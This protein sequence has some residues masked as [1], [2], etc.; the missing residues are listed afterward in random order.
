MNSTDK[1]TTNKNTTDV[2]LKSLTR[3]RYILAGLLA[4]LFLSFLWFS[5]KKSSVVQLPL[6]TLQSIDPS[7]NLPKPNPGSRQIVILHFWA[8]W[9]GP[10]KTELP[11]LLAAQSK[12]APTVDLLLISEDDKAEDALN[13]FKQLNPQIPT[14]FKYWDQTKSVSKTLGVFQFPETFIFDSQMHLIKKISGAMNW[15]E[16]ANLNYLQSLK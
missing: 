14:S 12:L 11:T 9:C 10:C 13:F 5:S 2:N 6:D 16:P 15:M 4:L 8:S 1:N 3:F 7:E